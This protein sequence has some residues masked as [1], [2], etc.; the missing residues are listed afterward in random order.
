MET[1][2]SPLRL[3]LT[4][5]LLQRPYQSLLSQIVLPQATQRL[6]PSLQTQRCQIRIPS[7]AH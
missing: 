5:L 4:R 3:A 2:L 6:V 1:Q 7:L